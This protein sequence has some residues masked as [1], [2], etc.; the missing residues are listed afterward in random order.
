[1]SPIHRLSSRWVLRMTIIMARRKSKDPRAK[2]AQIKWYSWWRNTRKDGDLSSCWIDVYNIHIYS[3]M[4]RKVR[5]M[6][7]EP[8]L[9]HC[10]S[11]DRDSW[12][13]SDNSALS[14]QGHHCLMSMSKKWCR[15]FFF[16][17]YAIVHGQYGDMSVWRIFNEVRKYFSS[18]YYLALQLT[19]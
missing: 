5:P 13:A 8:L 16:M 4:S 15:C 17:N 18:E 10:E 11:W 19:M 3:Y 12:A 14:S 9:N 2:I 6:M 1:M 7:I